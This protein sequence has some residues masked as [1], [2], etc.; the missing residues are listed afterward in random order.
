LNIPL[1]KFFCNLDKYGNTSAASI[2]IAFDEATKASIFKQGELGLF[3]AFGAGL[4][5][6]A[7]LVRF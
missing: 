5:W 2:P 1:D 6:S 7:I 3:V 4:T